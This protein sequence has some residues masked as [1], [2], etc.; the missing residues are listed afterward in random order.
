M[1]VKNVP[2]IEEVKNFLINT[3]DDIHCWKYTYQRE[4]YVKSHVY[5]KLTIQK[6]IP[7]AELWRLLQN[8]IHTTDK[9]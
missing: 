8:R 2:N 3:S 6:H 7:N 5:S 4:E 9:V 1:E